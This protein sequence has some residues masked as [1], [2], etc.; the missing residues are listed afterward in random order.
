MTPRGAAI[1]AARYRFKVAVAAIAKESYPLTDYAAL[2]GSPSRRSLA[3]RICCDRDH[4]R[5]EG[6]KIDQARVYVPGSER[7]TRTA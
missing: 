7:I 4:I 3:R 1:S 5:T 6:Y 2:V